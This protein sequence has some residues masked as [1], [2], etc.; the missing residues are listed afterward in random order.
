MKIFK[1]LRESEKLNA[2]AELRR[3]KE[4]DRRPLFGDPN[5]SGPLKIFSDNLLVDEPNVNFAEVEIGGQEGADGDDLRVMEEDDEPLT[6][7]QKDSPMPPPGTPYPELQDSAEGLLDKYLLRY[8]LSTSTLPTFHSVS[9][10]FLVSKYMTERTKDRAAFDKNT[11]KIKKSMTTAKIRR[12][13]KQI[14]HTRRLHCGA[15]K[16]GGCS[17]HGELA[18]WREGIAGY[19]QER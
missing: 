7:K 18:E 13:G 19:L 17:Q 14:P 3:N 4:K 6:M 11:T 9:D 5:E 8:S 1:R 2:K 15:H 12:G 10:A 16:S